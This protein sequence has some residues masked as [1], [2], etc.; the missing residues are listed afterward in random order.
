MA[1]KINNMP[2]THTLFIERSLTGTLAF[3]KESLYSEECAAR[4]GFLQSLDPRIKTVSFFIFLCVALFLKN[5]ALIGY[6]YIFCFFLS[7][8]SRIQPGFFLKRTL[9]FIPLFSLLIVVPAIFSIIT[10]G[11]EIASFHFGGMRLAVTRQGID[12]AALFLV[13]VST[14]VSFVVL[15]SLTT[16]HT[17]LLKVLRVFKIPQVFVMI[18][19][20]CYRYIYLFVGIVENSYLGIKS[21]VGGFIS[22][23]Q[24]RSLVAWKIASLWQRSFQMNEDVYRAMLSRGYSGETFVFEEFKTTVRDWVWL[25]LVIMMSAAIVYCSRR[26]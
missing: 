12:T 24:G 1:R 7:C 6:M 23:S 21:R 13:R 15:L 3:V 26:V 19:G 9:V 10:P 8:L 25:G 11:R 5:T 4:N 20:M 18:F 16:K 22:S 17:A 14:S 2:K